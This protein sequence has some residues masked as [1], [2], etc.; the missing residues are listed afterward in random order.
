[1][2]E[3]TDFGNLH[4]L[5]HFSPLDG[6]H[7]WRILVKREVGSCA[8][9]GREVPGQEAAEVPLA[10]NEDMVQTLAPD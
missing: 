1:M 10:E 6:P 9:I 2:M 3:G 4:N 7:V 5:A 8:V